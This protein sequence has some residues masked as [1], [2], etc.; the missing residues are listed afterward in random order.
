MARTLA[1]F[2]GAQ[3]AGTLEC[4]VRASSFEYDRAYLSTQGATPLSL[5]LPLRSGVFAPNVVDPFLWGLL[6]DNPETLQRWAVLA[7]PQ[8]DEHNPFSLLQHYGRDCAG[9]V[10]FLPEGEQPDTFQETQRVDDAAI[11]AQLRA[12]NADPNAWTFTDTD[13]RFS[14][15]GAQAKFALVEA[16]CGWGRAL[17]STPTTHIFKPGIPKFREQALNEHVCMELARQLGLPAAGT[18]IRSFD[19]SHAIVVERYDRRVTPAGIE[20]LHQEDLCQALSVS[21]SQKYQDDGG[22]GI[23]EIVSVFRREQPKDRADATARRFLLAVAFN[24]IIGAPDAHAKNYSL[25]LRG[26]TAV[27]APLYDIATITP[28][29]RFTPDTARSAQ[30]VNGSYRLVDIDVNAWHAQAFAVGLD[31]AEFVEAVRALAAR[32]PDEI[33]NLCTASDVLAIDAQF[34]AELRIALQRRVAVAQAQLR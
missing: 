24:W 6:P 18:H 31:G 27:L 11:G 25:L 20:R 32:A 7:S 4:N 30:A 17:G 2:M 33:D 22:P 9:A 21:P 14:L 19:G 12:L 5:S 3:R 23:S 8:A 34:A 26:S 29:D 16:D 15:A 28:Y 1:V 13:G 10:Q